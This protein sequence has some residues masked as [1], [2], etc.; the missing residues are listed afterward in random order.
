MSTSV[1]QTPTHSIGY[2]KMTPTATEEICDR[3]AATPGVLTTSYRARSSTRGHV[4][5]SRDRGY[6]GIRSGRLKCMQG[7][8]T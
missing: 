5:R 1:R 2:H 7:S 4:L 8:Q 3:S 6:N